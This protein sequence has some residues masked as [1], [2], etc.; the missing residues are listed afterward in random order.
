MKKKTIFR[1][2]LWLLKRTVSIYSVSSVFDSNKKM[3]FMT[4][5]SDAYEHKK[6][7]ET[8]KKTF[9]ATVTG[10]ELW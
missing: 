3:H 7:L 1:F 9:F 8:I 10:R 4:F 5:P 2:H 6:L